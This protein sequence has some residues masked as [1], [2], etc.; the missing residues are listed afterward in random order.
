MSILYYLKMTVLKKKKKKQEWVLK[1]RSQLL[2]C[3]GSGYFNFSLS[4]TTSIAHFLRLRLLSPP[5]SATWFVNF[6]TLPHLI[7]L[8]K[9]IAEANWIASVQRIYPY[10]PKRIW[11][12]VLCLLGHWSKFQTSWE[13]EGGSR[14]F[15]FSYST[16][17]AVNSWIL[18]WPREQKEAWFFSHGD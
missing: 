10:L 7:R 8:Q 2:A 9:Y 15:Y 3:F 11:I 17:S 12:H 13:G 6:I 4:N 5:P 18:I 16:C 14:Y 1:S